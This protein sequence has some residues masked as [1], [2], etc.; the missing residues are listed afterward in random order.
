MSSNDEP[1]SITIADSA[2]TSVEREAARSADGLET[3]GILLG[4]DTGARLDVRHAG[5]P[6]PK[7]QRGKR[8]FLRDLS[9]AQDLAQLAWETDQSQWIGEWHTHPA[10]P[11][12]PSERDLRSY[13]QHVHDPDLHLDRFL[14][15]II[16]P[17]TE[18]QAVISTWL[19]DR[20]SLWA[21]PLRRLNG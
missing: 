10:G 15:L 6:G 2:V 1:P 9:H 21:L 13:L 5:D 7:A 12:A 19:V 11:L 17:G 16:G 18:G 20:T 8:S 3:G 4:I 14:A